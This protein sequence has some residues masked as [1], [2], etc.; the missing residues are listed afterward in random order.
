MYWFYTYK[1]ASE[2]LSSITLNGFYAGNHANDEVCSKCGHQRAENDNITPLYKCPKCGVN[3]SELVEK[4]PQNVFTPKYETVKEVLQNSGSVLSP[5]ERKKIYEEEKFRLESKAKIEKEN[6]DAEKQDKKKK[7][8]EQ[9]KKGCLGCLSIF[10]VILLVSLTASF[11]S[12]K[13]SNYS[14]SNS[15]SPSPSYKP[16]S[17]LKPQNN[18]VDSIP[19]ISD[20]QLKSTCRAGCA[21][22]Y[23]VGTS[24][25]NDCVYCCTHDC[26]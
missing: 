13:S 10:G 22:L 1:A 18:E 8:D 19:G 17:N 25:Y 9:T 3:Y 14:R 26:Q 23:S 12:E 6:K 15:Y 20:S 16:Y 21:M 2:D 24:E 7:Q 4:I 5:E 11:C